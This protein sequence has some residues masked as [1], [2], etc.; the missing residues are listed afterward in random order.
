MRSSWLST[1]WQILGMFFSS[2]SK[3]QLFVCS[4]ADVNNVLS[5]YLGGMT[6]YLANGGFQLAI[7]W[8]SVMSS[9]VGPVGKAS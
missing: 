7:Y 9:I 8:Q 2:H 6:I 4:T 1:Q 5:R 3:E